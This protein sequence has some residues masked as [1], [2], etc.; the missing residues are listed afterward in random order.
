MDKEDCS[1]VTDV[2]V[3]ELSVEKSKPPVDL[4]INLKIPL[5]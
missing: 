5:V 1:S 3:N 4:T 2:T